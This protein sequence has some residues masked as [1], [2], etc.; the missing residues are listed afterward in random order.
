MAAVLRGKERVIGTI[1]LGNRV[2]ITRGF[3]QD[4]L[5]LFETLAANASAALQFDR[6][7]Q[8]VIELRDL[9]HQLHHQSLSRP[10]DRPGRTA[11]SSCRRSPRRCTPRGDPAVLFIDLDDF[12]GVNDTLGHAVGD[13]LLSRRAPR[14]SPG[15][16]ASRTWSPGSAAT[17]SPCSYRADD[18]RDATTAERVIAAF[19]AA[20]AIGGR[21][22]PTNVSVGV[23]TGRRAAAAE[24]LRDA[25]VAMYEAKA[26]GKARLA[27]FT[28]GMRDAV[29]RRHA[30]RDEL[31]HAIEREQLLVQ[32]QPIVDLRSGEVAA[33]EALVRW[34]HP[35]HG[36]IPPIEFIPLAE[37]TVAD[38]PAR[39]LRAAPGVRAGHGVDGRRRRADQS[40]RSTFPRA[41]S[42]TPT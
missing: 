25:D 20:V 1:M 39:P 17:S 5:A 11:R 32:Y 26:A 30:L 8:A 23:A 34:Q 22:L 40:C 35:E 7:E 12:K 19:T 38:R 21:L 3:G 10:A 4:D 31:E 6:L 24:L 14:A 13:Q 36:R 18:D 37:E 16:R 9:Q 29:L 28:P 27:V 2:G 15:R 42:R 41:S 33:V